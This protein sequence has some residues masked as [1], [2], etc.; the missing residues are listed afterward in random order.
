MSPSDKKA[1]HKDKDTVRPLCPACGA[2]SSS[3][4]DPRANP[5]SCFWVKDNIEG[6]NRAWKDVDWLNSSEYKELAKTGKT[7]LGNAKK[8]DTAT[9]SKGEYC[10][11][12]DP[13]LN[14]LSNSFLT[15]P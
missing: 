13:I 8:K 14:H 10:I 4:H 11:S 9:D 6:H 7:Y 12:C 5:D 3:K 15:L 2:Y 1:T